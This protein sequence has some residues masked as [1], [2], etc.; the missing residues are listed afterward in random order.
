MID[1]T[2]RSSKDI[3]YLLKS[4]FAIRDVGH[5]HYFLGVELIVLS[6]G[7]LLSQSKYV[8]QTRKIEEDYNQSPRHVLSLPQQAIFLLQIVLLIE[9]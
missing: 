4:D 7:F 2:S 5:A 1:A 3:I 6:Q 9:A 8:T